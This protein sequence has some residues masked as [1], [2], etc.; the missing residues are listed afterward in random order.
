MIAYDLHPQARLD[1]D[2]IWEFIAEDSLDAADKVIADI[3]A[4]TD[5]LVTFP[6]QG[7]KRPD[8]TS[9]PFWVIGNAKSPAP[10]GLMA[11]AEEAGQPEQVSEVVPGAVVV[12]LVDVQAVDEQRDDKYEGGNETLPQSEPESGDGVLLA[13]CALHGVGAGGTGG[14]DE[15]KEESE[16]ECREFHGGGLLSSVRARPE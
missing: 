13:R 14:E 1:L 3:L 9:R 11:A 7:H 16:D 12:D 4:S 5:R 2:D 8:L 6:N 10:S 15:E